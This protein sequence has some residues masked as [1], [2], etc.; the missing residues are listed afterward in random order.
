MDRKTLFTKMSIIPNL[1]Y[2]FD[3]MPIKILAS[4]SEGEIDKFTTKFVR[5]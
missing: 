1:I 2:R 3:A 5:R 4:F